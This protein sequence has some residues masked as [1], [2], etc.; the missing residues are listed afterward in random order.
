MLQERK[1]LIQHHV[2]LLLSEAGVQKSQK[3]LAAQS[4]R[5]SKETAKQAIACSKHPEGSDKYQ[6]CFF[7]ALYGQQQEDVLPGASPEKEEG[8]EPKVPSKQKIR[9]I[10][11]TLKGAEAVAWWHKKE[12]EKRLGV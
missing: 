5:F 2:N 3:D 11:D 4:N 7:D 6:Q 1:E 9:H 10:L 12:Q 8:E